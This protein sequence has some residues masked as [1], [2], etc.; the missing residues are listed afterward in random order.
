MLRK[1]ANFFGVNFEFQ[2]HLLKIFLNLCDWFP[3][4]KSGINFLGMKIKLT[5]ICNNANTV[6]LEVFI[7][8]FLQFLSNNIFFYPSYLGPTGLIYL[9]PMLHLRRNQVIGLFALENV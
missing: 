9:Q 8:F 2:M 6:F 3:K 1:F 4:N 5:L 7:Q